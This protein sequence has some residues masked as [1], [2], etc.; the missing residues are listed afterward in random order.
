VGKGGR[1]G[2]RVHVM[3]ENSLVKLSL[4]AVIQAVCV[5]VCVCIC[6]CVSVTVCP[7]V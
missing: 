5:C 3:A 1:K 7:C 6:V 4:L 2:K